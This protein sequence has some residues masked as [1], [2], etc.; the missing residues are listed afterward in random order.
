MVNFGPLK[1]EICWRVWGTPTNFNGFRALASL[2]QW[3]RSTEVNQSSH[4]IWPSPGLIYYI[5]ILG[6]LT[7]NGILPCAKFNLRPSL[8]FSYIGSDTARHSS[9]C[10]SHTLRHRTR[11]GIT[12]L[13]FLVIFNRRRQLYSEGGHHVGHRPTFY[14]YFIGKAAILSLLPCLQLWVTFD[15]WIIWE[16]CDPFMNF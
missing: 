7:P 10:V 4:D 16:G 11:N 2:L 5:Y 13:W 3:R 9:M 14:S 6:A 15:A 12:E 8:A 1:A